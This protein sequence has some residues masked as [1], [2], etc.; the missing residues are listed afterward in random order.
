MQ[1]SARGQQGRPAVSAPSNKTG[2]PR[3]R[4]LMEERR[5]EIEGLFARDD[6]PTASADRAIGLAIE[7]YR[8]VQATSKD[9]INEKSVVT[10]ALFAFQRK[11]DP[12]VDVYFVPY[13]GKVTPQISPQGLINLAMRSGMVTSVDARFVFRKEVDDGNF[14]HQLGLEPKIVH[15]KGSCARPVDPQQAYRELAFTY[16]IVHLKG[17]GPPIVEVHDKGDIEWHRSLSKNKNNPDGLWGKFPVEAARKAVLKQALNRAP[18]QAEVSIIL[19][20]EAALEAEA[21]DPGA[22][23]WGNVD[24]RLGVEGQPQAT[25]AAGKPNGKQAPPNDRPSGPAQGSALAGDPAKIKMPG[26]QPTPPIADADPADLAKW[27]GILRRDLDEGGMDKPD[28]ARF[29][30]G[31]IKCLATIRARM[32]SIDMVVTPH[33][34]LDV[35]VD[36]APRREPDPSQGEL[37][38]DQEAEMLAASG[39]GDTAGYAD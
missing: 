30:D 12:G 15:K 28:K 17:G 35:G 33:E 26:K 6:N 2:E 22:E 29:K 11:L 20:Q 32:R 4:E 25:A 23:F 7:V 1:P 27:E 18:K 13:A 3:I 24:A 8:D 36:L 39:G 31:N 37:T 10:S 21:M 38:P 34:V 9:V 5:A 14:D 19:A 16:A